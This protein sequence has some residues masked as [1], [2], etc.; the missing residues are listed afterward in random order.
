MTC[1]SKG[2]KAQ[3]VYIYKDKMEENQI[4]P[5]IHWNILQTVWQYL[6]HILYFL[7]PHAI[8]KG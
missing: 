3:L 8:K 2:T 7:F 5:N 4:A 1:I 6:M